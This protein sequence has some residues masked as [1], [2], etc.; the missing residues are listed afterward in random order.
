M[1]AEIKKTLRITLQ[2]KIGIEFLSHTFVDAVAVVSQAPS[3]KNIQLAAI[4][5]PCA[6]GQ[7]LQQ[8]MIIVPGKN[9]FI[10]HRI[11]PDFLL[12]GVQKIEVQAQ[13]P[14][15]VEIGQ[16]VDQFVFFGKTKLNDCFE[17]VLS[18]GKIGVVKPHTKV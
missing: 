3:V 14:A 15:F 13:C 11:E 2:K 5:Q 7:P 16:G 12:P 6:D 18:S 17:Q 4:K 8:R 1:V 10:I 9:Q